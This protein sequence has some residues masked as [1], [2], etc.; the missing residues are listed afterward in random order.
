MLAFHETYAYTV[1]VLVRYPSLHSFALMTNITILTAL[2]TSFHA[3]VNDSLLLT[4]VWYRSYTFLSF[5]YPALNLHAVLFR[6]YMIWQRQQ[7][8]SFLGT[9]VF[10]SSPDVKVLGHHI[11]K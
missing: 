7:S 5:R 10:L 6:L 3:I 9:T 8:E 2:L 1:Q 11:S 4:W